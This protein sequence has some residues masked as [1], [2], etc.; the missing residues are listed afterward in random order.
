MIGSAGEGLQLPVATAMITWI[1]LDYLMM[2]N[3]SPRHLVQHEACQIA[4]LILAI[5]TTLIAVMDPHDVQTSTMMTCCRLCGIRGKDI[6][7]SLPWHYLLEVL[8]V[9]LSVAQ[10]KTS[11][12]RK[13]SALSDPCPRSHLQRFNMA[14]NICLI[15]MHALRPYRR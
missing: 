7:D 3:L 5:R 13:A 12:S 6:L 14:A 15:S 9:E 10:T 1:F 8:D 2:H 11:S 4:G